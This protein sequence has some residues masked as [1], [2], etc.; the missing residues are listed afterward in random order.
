MREKADRWAGTNLSIFARATVCNMFFVSKLYYVMQVLFCS[1]A[2]VQRLHRVFAVFIWGSTWER[3]S[4]TNLFRR[5]KDGGV[6]LVHLFVRQLVNRFLFFRDERDPFLRTVCQLRLGDALPAHVVSTASMT[7]T[8]RGYFKEVVDSVR[9]LSVRF[10]ND[11]LCEVKRKTLYR[12]LC[13]VLLP[14][15]LYR[16]IYSGGPGQDVLRRVK[17][18]Q[19]PPGVKTFFFM[20]HTG[21]LPVKTFMKERGC[22]VPWG[23]HCLICKQPETIDHVFLHCWEGVYFWDVLQR[24]LKK[25][26]P[27]D[28]H[29][30]RFLACKDDDGVPYD[31]IML[32]ALHCL[33][34]ARMKGY[35]CDPDARPA[36]I[37]FKQC[38]ARF[39]EA[40]R[41]QECVP[42]WLSRLE[43]LTTMKEF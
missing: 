33:W 2:N 36:R 9:F 38:I 5:V 4:R 19:V 8:P 16:A 41:M 43:P 29:G 39:I 1:R 15:P 21:T 28:P 34:Q 7:R 17:R 10:S 11:Y 3:C 22:T 26:L 20:L 24:T 27:L 32:N 14:V 12:D 31:F 6:G 25:E 23:T 13:E 37:Y 42:D 40:Q 18:M 35:H 30:I